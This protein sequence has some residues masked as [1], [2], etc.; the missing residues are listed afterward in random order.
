MVVTSRL[1]VAGSDPLASE[2]PPCASGLGLG[3]RLSSPHSASYPSRLPCCTHTTPWGLYLPSGVCRVLSVSPR[4][5]TC[6]RRPLRCPLLPSLYARAGDIFT[7]PS[8][9]V[10]M[11]SLSCRTRWAYQM[12]M[13]YVLSRRSRCPTHHGR[14]R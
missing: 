11:T 8:S 13:P 3:P 12:T 6:V 1:L 7:L 14:R 9:S 4:A 2:I 10:Y 5:C